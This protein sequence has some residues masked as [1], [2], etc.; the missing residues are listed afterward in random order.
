M[1]HLQPGHRYV[2]SWNSQDLGQ[3]LTNTLAI[4]EPIFYFQYGYNPALVTG[5]VFTVLFGL[6]AL[7][8]FGLSLTWRPKWYLVVAAGATGEVI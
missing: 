6:M 1:L 3:K 8:H 5:I 7:I 2:S 4:G